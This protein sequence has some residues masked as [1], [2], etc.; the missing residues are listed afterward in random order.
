MLNPMRKN[1]FSGS[2]MEPEIG[3]SRAVRVGPFVFVAGTAPIAA[4]GGTEAPGDVY[5][6]TLRCIE[7]AAK[8]IEEA[9]ASL[10]DVVRTRIMLVDI[11]RWRE[12]AQA[13]GEVFSGIQ[14]ACTFVEVSRFIEPEWLVEVELDCVVSP[15]VGDLTPF[16]DGS[17]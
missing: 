3:F 13:H 10:N 7:I 12:A 5:R 6:Q 11:S 16:G 4:G 17:S 15:S 14:P 9:D 8:A 2:P 1:V